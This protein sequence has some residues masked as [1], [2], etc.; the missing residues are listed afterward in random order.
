MKRAN[1]H[2]NGWELRRKKYGPSG[3]RPIQ[4]L[5]DPPC[6][7]CGGPCLFDTVVPSAVWNDVIRSAGL[8]EYL[9]AACI[10]QEFAKRDV[11][12]T[13]ELIGG[14]FH[15]LPVS[16][17]FNSRRARTA[18][19]VSE[20]NTDLR[21]RLRQAED[22]CQRFREQY[23]AA[24]VAAVRQINI[25]EPNMDQHFG[26]LRVYEAAF[27]TATWL[28][29]IVPPPESATKADAVDP[30]GEKVTG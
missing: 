6:G 27:G 15:M 20:E 14:G 29:Q 11:S 5:P 21:Y 13:C 16:V 12:F 22:A 23:E 26:A 24:R 30:V 9:C 7:L 1:K 19:R 28:P 10:L 2:P 3:R 8:P 18:Q 4:S 25:V 17:H